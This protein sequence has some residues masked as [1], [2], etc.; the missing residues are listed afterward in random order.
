MSDQNQPFKPM[1]QAYQA[2]QGPTSNRIEANGV[3]DPI[4][5]VAKA[6]IPIAGGVLGGPLGASLGAL[7]TMGSEAIGSSQGP[8]VAQNRADYMRQHGLAPGTQIGGGGAPGSATAAID[9]QT[10]ANRP[11][12]ASPWGSSEWTKDAKGNWTQNVNLS[13]QMG[14]TNDLLQQQAHINALRG[15]D[16]GEQTRDKVITSAYD[17][18]ASRLN[19]QWQQRD[20]LLASTLANQGLDPN[21]QA[22]RNA[23]RQQGQQRN[24]AYSSAMANAIAQGTSAQQAQFQQD[25]ARQKLPYEQ[26]GA[27][28]QLATPFGFHASA[29]PDVLGERRLNDEGKRYDEGQKAQQQQA[30]FGLLGDLFNAGAP[31]LGGLFNFGGGNGQTSQQAGDE[32]FDNG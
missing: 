1:N 17:Q 14:Q 19:P 16:T 7:F 11:D 12:Q 4:W 13:G 22:Y 15:I 31:L 28:K 9:Q 24:D 29:A 6:A 2:P 23:M 8:N 5:G 26:M 3:P 10:Q 25:L 27:T 32:A 18:S 20:E 30:M 21:S